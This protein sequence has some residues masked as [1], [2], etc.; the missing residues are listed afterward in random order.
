MGE[1][2]ACSAGGDTSGCPSRHWCYSS[3]DLRLNGTSSDFVC[4]CY[5]QLLYSGENCQKNSPLAYVTWAFLTAHFLYSFVFLIYTLWRLK[6]R[7]SAQASRDFVALLILMPPNRLMHGTLLGFDGLR[8]INPEFDDSW[9][10][11][12]G[13]KIFGGVALFCGCFK[14]LYIGN[15]LV[16]R[17][18]A[19]GAFSPASSKR[20][21]TAFQVLVAIVL[22]MA[23][24]SPIFLSVSVFAA[25]ICLVV[26]TVVVFQRK[27]VHHAQTFLDLAPE[28]SQQP[29]VARTQR[30][31]Q[32]YTTELRKWVGLFVLGMA[33]AIVFNINIAI[34][35]AVSHLAMTASVFS[36]NQWG[37]CDC[38]FLLQPEPR[39]Q[40]VDLLL[41]SIKAKFPWRNSSSQLRIAPAD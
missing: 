5:R 2:I 23:V 29:T 37:I 24:A 17:L 12:V 38:D 32:N 27:A 9:Y 36:V 14:T 20:I 7:S 6:V 28:I 40:F 19:V 11:E 39:F 25:F 35:A 30:Q 4:L 18:Q 33:G 31:L 1:V 34:P 41:Q 3:G 21:K 13:V 16:S 26:V 10:Q 8:L 15:L 22:I